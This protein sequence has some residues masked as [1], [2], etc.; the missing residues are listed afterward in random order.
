MRCDSLQVDNWKTWMEP[1][2]IVHGHP[3]GGEDV[4]AC[5]LPR[6]LYAFSSEVLTW[7]ASSCSS[8]FAAAIATCTRCGSS[9]LQRCALVDARTCAFSLLMECT[10][11]TGAMT[12][13]KTWHGCHIVSRCGHVGCCARA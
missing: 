2:A 12:T 5:L 4:R 7:T 8:S 6:P 13:Q 11:Q 10:A 9:N 1:A 3:E